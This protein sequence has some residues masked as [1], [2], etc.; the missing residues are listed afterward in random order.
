LAAQAE[1]WVASS[2]KTC[3]DVDS[4]RIVYD[5][6]NNPRVAFA[7]DLNCDRNHRS[8][9][10]QVNSTIVVIDC[11]WNWRG[12]KVF[13]IQDDRSIWPAVDNTLRRPHHAVAIP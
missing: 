9:P 8:G 3:I 10:R 11:H 13:Q 7:V 4:Y 2:D 12:I 5:S 1:N 6:D